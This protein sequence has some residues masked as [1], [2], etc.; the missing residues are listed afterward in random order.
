MHRPLSAVELADCLAACAARGEKVELQGG[1]TRRA[2]GAPRDAEIVS[3]AGMTGIVDYDPA[4][5]IM[6]VRGGTALAEVESEVA[7][8]GQR[9]AFDPVDPTGPAP[10]TTIGGA[11]IGGFSGPGRLGGGGARDHLLGF[12]AVSGRGEVFRAGGNVV[13]NVTGYDLPKVIAGSWGRLAAVC[14]LTLKVMPR[15]R[16]SQTLALRTRDPAGAYTAMSLAMRSRCTPGAVAHL[17]LDGIT[18]FRIEGFDRSVIS[19]RETLQQLCA[20]LGT[21]DLLDDGEAQSRWDDVRTVRPLRDAAML[22]RLAIPPSAGPKIVAALEPLGASWVADW[23]GALIWLALEDADAVRSSVAA[24]GGHAMLVR[25]PDSAWRTVP[26]MQPRNPVLAA[27]EARV[28]RGFDPA[29]IFET[30]RFL[31]DGRAN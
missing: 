21:V 17:P 22:W 31:D 14:E 4:E 30:G 13:K 11:V 8:A 26:A 29:G 15:P 20:P 3:L 19:R 16:T 27:L 9:L 24:L 5:L 10:E 23:A 12:T 2:I 7:N 6:V 18:L 1:G 28:R 25:A